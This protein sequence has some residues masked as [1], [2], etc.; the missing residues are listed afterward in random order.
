MFQCSMGEP[1]FDSRN[2]R[3]GTEVLAF[4]SKLML[5]GGELK[6]ALG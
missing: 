4:W 5:C 6:M 2:V 3:I 1:I